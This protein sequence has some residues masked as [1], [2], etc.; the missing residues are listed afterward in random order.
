MSKRSPITVIAAACNEVEQ[1]EEWLESLR[2]VDRVVVIDTGSH[3]G[4]EEVLAGRGAEVIARRPQEDAVIHAAKNHAIDQ[5]TEGW[6]LDLDLDERVSR[7]LRAELEK[8]AADDSDA[9]AF[10][11]PFRHYIF[12]R[13]VR[14]GGWSGK[15]LRFYR[16]GKVRYPTDRVHSTPAVDGAV[17]EL[18]GE[19]LHFA[20]PTLHDFIVKMN[21]YTSHDAPLMKETGRG[22]LRNR[23]PLAP[24]KLSWLRASGSVFW[25]RYVKAAG[26]R[27]GVPGFL[28]AAMLSAYAFV[29]QAKVWEADLPDDSMDAERGRE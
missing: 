7:E 3:D 22:G 13:W 29:E 5:V 16:A 28:A 27:D 15:H 20:H 4:T 12:G 19:V 25:N 10:R 8:I 1:A 2:W 17:R 6:I 14:H 26:F 9:V 24:G 11:V 23:A 18:D 21:R